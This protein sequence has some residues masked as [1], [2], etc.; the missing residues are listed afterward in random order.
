MVR[1][2]V[3][4]ARGAQIVRHPDTCLARRICP[5]LP[6]VSPPR[7]PLP[8]HCIRPPVPATPLWRHT[9]LVINEGLIELGK[10]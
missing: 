4:R 6:G 1:P 8:V 2:A 10:I 3:W 7:E 9:S 5:V